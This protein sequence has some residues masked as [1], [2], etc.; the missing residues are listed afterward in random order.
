MAEKT[1][2]NEEYKALIT[3]IIEKQAVILG[4]DI[5]ILKARSVPGLKVSDD[6][7]VTDIQADA[8]ETVQ[9][10][11]DEYVDL[12]GQIIKGALASVFTKYPSLNKKMNNK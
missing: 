9:K 8:K 4:P 5:A 7:K 1:P 2:S 6:G 11:I 3:E 10:L 12:S